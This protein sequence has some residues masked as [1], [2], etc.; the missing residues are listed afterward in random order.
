MFRIVVDN[1][2]YTVR[3]YHRKENNDCRL[4]DKSSHNDVCGSVFSITVMVVGVIDIIKTKIYSYK[5]LKTNFFYESIIF[6]PLHDRVDGKLH[7]KYVPNYPL[8][9]DRV[10]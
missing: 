5:V 9:L 8:I 1:N 10:V 6:S 7:H 3:C 2:R 4:A